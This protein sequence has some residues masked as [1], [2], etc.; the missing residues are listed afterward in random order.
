MAKN[1][2]KDKEKKVSE[3]INIIKPKK[4][5]DLSSFLKQNYSNW[6]DIQEDIK[7]TYFILSK[8]FQ[9]HLKEISSGALKLYLYYC[10]QSKN[11]TGESWHSVEKIH[12]EL[13]VSERSINLW[14]KELEERGLIS[15]YTR[16]S[17]NKTTYLIP[18]S[19]NIIDT[20]DKKCFFSKA[21]MANK[22]FKEVFGEV[23]KCYHFF[24][25]RKDQESEQY[26]FPYHEI[27]VVFIKKFEA[28]YYF[29]YSAFRLPLESSDII[30]ET[31][32]DD[33]IALFESSEIIDDIEIKEIQGIA[34]NSKFN[35]K[36]P[37]VMYDLLTQL[38]SAEFDQNDFET[39]T[40]ESKEDE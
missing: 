30:S 2:Q 10:F 5:K 25:W 1:T 18:L 24:Q 39:I 17:N 37:K 7:G 40:L 34:I 6:R 38:L 36:Q 23:Y 4:K 12:D 19:L 13:G 29:Q 28:G 20:S 8:A 21:D 9:I 14:N 3:T 31:N 15:R 33:D 32:L 22:D 11:E 26:T 35:I 16:G 27:V